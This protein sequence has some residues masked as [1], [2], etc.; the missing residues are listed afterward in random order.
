MGFV[1][2]LLLGALAFA[3]GWAIRVYVLSKKPAPQ[4]PYSLKHPVILQYLAIFFAIMLVVSWMIG[5]FL[6]GH[7]HMDVLFIIINSAVAT[8]VFS[9]GL[10]PDLADYN[11]PD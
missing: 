1:N 7:E 8:F 3:S 11:V 5:K 9:F 2:Y 10:S 4:I 6:L